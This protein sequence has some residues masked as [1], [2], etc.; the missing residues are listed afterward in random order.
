MKDESLQD[1]FEGLVACAGCSFFCPAL[2]QSHRWKC[3]VLHFGLPDAPTL[4]AC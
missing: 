2:H 1:E 4:L 3:E